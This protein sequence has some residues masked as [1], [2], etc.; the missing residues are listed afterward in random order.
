V[1]SPARTGLDPRLASVLSYS[2]WWVTGLVFLVVARDDTRVRFHA[3]QS[4]VIFGAVSLLLLALAAL[5]ITTLVVWPPGYALVQR[6]SEVVWLGAVVLWIVLMLKAWRGDMW[7]VP[8]AAPL[9][10]R[11]I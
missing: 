7:R 9:A 6:I 1:T 11:M 2:V 8:F 10:E 5:S 3:A 4:I